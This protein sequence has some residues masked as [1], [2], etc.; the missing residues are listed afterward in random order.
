LRSYS[1][2]ID[3]RATSRQYIDQFAHIAPLGASLGST[4]I[5]KRHIP[6]D[7]NKPH[8]EV[9]DLTELIPVAEYPHK[10]LLNRVMSAI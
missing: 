8:S 5:V 7:P 9:L 4:L 3:T 2:L 10:H 1:S 6:G